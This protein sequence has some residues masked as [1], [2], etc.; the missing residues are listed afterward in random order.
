MALAKDTA[1][2]FSC[3]VSVAPVTSWLL[4]GQ[5]VVIVVFTFLIEMCDHTY[6][7]LLTPNVI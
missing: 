3:G 4:Y 2:V 6:Q 1:D 5:F 7:I